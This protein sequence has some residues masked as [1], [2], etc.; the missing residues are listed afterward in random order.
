MHKEL[1]QRIFSALIGGTICILGLVYGAYTFFLLF[2]GIMLL[3][4]W[5]FY[6]LLRLRE[7][8]HP[9]RIGGLVLS[10]VLFTLSF[11]W[12]QGLI[13]GEAFLWLL[14]SSFAL[15]LANLFPLS[16]SRRKLPFVNVGSTLLGVVYVGG[17]FSM[18]HW[19]VFRDNEYHYEL[20]LG[21]LLMVW[22]SDIGGYFVGK[23]LGRHK[24]YAKISP[25]KTWEGFLGSALLASITAVSF[26]YATEKSIKNWILLSICVTF[27]S[28]LGDFNESILKRA[29]GVKDSGKGLPGHGGWLDR[30]DS[31]LFVFAFLPPILVLVR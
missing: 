14:P 19:L 17:S 22:S 30:F 31:M 24:L 6:N 5:E 4:Q 28:T 29:L 10:A 1:A 13:T 8:H 26:A 7:S 20:L 27:L 25:K 12:K 11:V 15:F 3:T 21:L 2:L 9:F 16:T 23:R 18:V